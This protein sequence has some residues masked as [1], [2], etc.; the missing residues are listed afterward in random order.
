MPLRELCSLRGHEDRVWCADWHPHGDMIASCSGDRTVRVWRRFDSAG[1]SSW[2][3]VA[4]LS[5]T[6]AR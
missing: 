1:D 3:L 4:T 5:G 2:V 6:K